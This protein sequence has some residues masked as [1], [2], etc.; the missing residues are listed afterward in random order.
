MA[1][2]SLAVC[3]RQPAAHS[4]Y[5]IPLIEHYHQ[6]GRTVSP[7][8]EVAAIAEAKQLGLWRQMLNTSAGQQSNT[9]PPGADDND[10]TGMGPRGQ[11][12]CLVVKVA[13]RKELDLIC[14]GKQH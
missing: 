4:I 14:A 9:W 6:F 7:A 1:T 11:R 3:L 12:A 13:W 2:P 10:P 8:A 5:V